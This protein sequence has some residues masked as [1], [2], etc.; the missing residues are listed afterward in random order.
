MQHAKG[1]DNRAKLATAAPS[2]NSEQDNNNVKWERD[3]THGKR[4]KV[5]KVQQ[6][7]LS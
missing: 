7:G 1:E 3:G 4:V 5:K 6:I 2:N